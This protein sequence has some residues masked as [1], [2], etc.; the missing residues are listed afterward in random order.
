MTSRVTVDMRTCGKTSRISV[1]AREDGGCRVSISSDCPDVEEYARRIAV[2]SKDDCEGLWSGRIVDP[3]ARSVL[4]DTCL[5]PMGVMY[6]VRL[7]TGSLS[8]E[9]ARAAHDN[10]IVIDPEDQGLRSWT[11]GS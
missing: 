5:C 1:T 3:D 7:E 4:S 6:A 2:L 9:K 8:A 10:R 11:S